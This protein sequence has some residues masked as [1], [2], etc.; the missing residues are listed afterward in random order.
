ML[1]RSM[2]GRVACLT[3]SGWKMWDSILLLVS[4]ALIGTQKTGRMMIESRSKYIS[5]GFT[6]QQILANLL[7]VY[8]FTRKLAS[9]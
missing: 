5:L 1:Q 7:K 3:G 8:L 2:A 9:S 6:Q 4:E